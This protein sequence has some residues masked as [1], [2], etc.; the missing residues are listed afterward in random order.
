M[1]NRSAAW[2]LIRKMR[3]KFLLRH[4]DIR[5]VLIPNAVFTDQLTE[6]RTGK[7]FYTPMRIRVRYR[8][9][10]IRMIR[11][12]YSQICG[13]EDKAPG[14]MAHG[15]EKKVGCSDQWMEAL[16]GKK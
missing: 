8:L 9:P 5:M 2:R 12:S 11:I 4:W 14:K 7:K 6:E 15:M 16:P 3:T 1:Y 10:S 13:R